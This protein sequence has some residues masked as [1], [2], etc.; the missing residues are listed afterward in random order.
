MTEFPDLGV[1]IQWL[2]KKR[3]QKEL[4][5]VKAYYKGPV[6]DRKSLLL[7]ELIQRIRQQSDTQV[8]SLCVLVY[9]IA[10]TSSLIY[11][12]PFGQNRNI[13]NQIRCM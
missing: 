11:E 2:F 1:S 9:T 3:V 4:T 10:C 7:G 6:C 8:S 13:S 5:V 12:S